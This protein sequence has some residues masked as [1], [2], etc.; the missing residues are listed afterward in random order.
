MK[1][2]VSRLTLLLK[3]VGDQERVLNVR[4]YARPLSKMTL[5]QRCSAIGRMSRTQWQQSKQVREGN[6]K[7]FEYYQQALNNENPTPAR[8]APRS[9]DCR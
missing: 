4:I 6:E 9:A 7:E 8:L 5:F 3:V 1:E 2:K